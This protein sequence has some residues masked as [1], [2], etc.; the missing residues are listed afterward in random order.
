MGCKSYGVSSIL[1]GLHRVGVV[2]LARALERADEAGLTED[3]H[4]EVVA[5]MMEG[6]SRDNYIP[7]QQRAEFEAALFREFLRH[8]GKDIHEYFSELPV[9]VT[10]LPGDQR[11]QVAELVRSVLA[12]FELKPVF[13][14]CTPT[15]QDRDLTLTIGH[16]TVSASGLD[17]TQLQAAV[18]RRVSEW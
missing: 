15:E 8:R 12:A 1:V 3:N 2:G 6:L 7:E 16:E 5:V 11:E 10:A 9:R 4:A 18:R 17:R 14:Y 13:E